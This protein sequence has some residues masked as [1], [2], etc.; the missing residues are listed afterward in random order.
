MIGRTLRAAAALMIGAAT[1]VAGGGGPSPAAADTP[2]YVVYALAGGNLIRFSSATPGTIDA[3]VPITGVAAGDVLHGIDIRPATGQLYGIGVSSAPTPDTLRLY[4]IDRAT[5]QA[6]ALTVGAVNATGNATRYSIDFNP[7]SDRVR[8]IDDLGGNQRLNPNNGA[9]AAN[10]SPLSPVGANVRGIAY[11]RNVAARTAPPTTPTTLYA[12]KA[13]GNLV[14]VGGLN[15]TPSPNGGVVTTVGPL[16]AVPGSNSVGFDITA[17]NVGLASIHV[18]I[19][20]YL[21]LVDL[22]SGDATAIGA[23]GTGALQVRDIAVDAVGLAAGASQY[24]GVSSYRLVDT[25]ETGGKVAAG[26]V[27]TVPVTNRGPIPATGVTAA[28]LNVTVTQPEAP[29]YTTVW[30]SGTPM[31]NTSSVNVDATDQTRAALVTVPVGADGAVKVFS[32]RGSHVI[33]DVVG[34]FKP[35]RDNQGRLFTLTPSR[36]LDTRTGLG[37]PNDAPAKPGDGATVELTVAGRGGVPATGATAAVVNVTMTGTNAP[38]F[39]TVYAGDVAQPLASNLNA[40]S[41]GETIANLAIVPIGAAGTV[42]LFTERGTELIVDVVGYFAADSLVTPKG[43]F[44]PVNP[45]RILDTRIGLGASQG[46]VGPG[47]SIN[48]TIA[49][50]GGVPATGVLAVAGTV[51]ATESQASGF[52]TV[53]PTSDSLPTASTLNTVR[54]GQTIANSIILGLGTQGQ[55]TLYSETGTHLLADVTGYFSS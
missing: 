54:A 1:L 16:G 51:T 40:S 21:H 45:Q 3:T 44:V 13:D 12:I 30:P 33:A 29:G 46:S 42:K 10:D 14:H 4:T 32:E 22:T 43:L 38:G 20:D 19:G 8:V 17:D 23:I 49:G 39:V 5:G 31:T 11:D 15:G 26:G 7:A 52:V 25:R 48:T 34:Y 18:G 9:L 36:L 47:W 50:N 6:T 55:L 28:V 27:L 24:V 35:A 53:Y 37:Q 2:A 41:A